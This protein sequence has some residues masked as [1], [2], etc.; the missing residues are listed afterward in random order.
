MNNSEVK[1]SLKLTTLL[2]FASLLTAAQTRLPPA[3]NRQVHTISDPA[4]HGNEPSIAINPNNP[5]QI[6]AA[7]QPVT[8]VYSQDGGKT[9]A[10]AD[11]PAVEGW[12][13]GGDVSV[14]FDSKGNAYL[15]TLHFEKLGN[16]SRIGRTAQARIR[17]PFS[18]DLS[19]TT[20]LPVVT[21][22]TTIAIHKC[23]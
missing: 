14:A 6:I 16:T 12:R 5:Q 21:T 1:L 8:V 15:S 22:R 20:C 11:L 10:T 3:P 23:F 17:S 18:G 4:A 9:F 13:G 19:P 2:L 7:Y